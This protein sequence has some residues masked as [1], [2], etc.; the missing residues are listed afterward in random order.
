MFHIYWTVFGQSAHLI[1]NNISYAYQMTEQ[2]RYNVS[3]IDI[4][5][6]STESESWIDWGTQC[7][8]VQCSQ[9]IHSAVKQRL[10]Y[11]STFFAMSDGPTYPAI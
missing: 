7:S 10:I 5:I 11:M 8:L 3:F 2:Y 4:F 6:M 1:L 9:N